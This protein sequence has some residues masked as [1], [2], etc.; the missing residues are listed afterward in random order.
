MDLGT[1]IAIQ[2]GVWLALRAWW[3]IR[4]IVD[5]RHKDQPVFKPTPYP[6][7][8]GQGGQRLVVERPGS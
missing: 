6:R 5:T 3:D 2:G 8:H 1:I 4:T 7:S